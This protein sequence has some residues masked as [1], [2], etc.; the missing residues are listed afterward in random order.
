MEGTSYLV[1][2]VK[3]ALPP[4]VPEKGFQ[5]IGSAEYCVQKLRMLE[6]IG[7]KVFLGNEYDFPLR[8]VRNLQKP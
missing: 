5:I 3:E 2:A 7:K 8:G 1:Q 6:L 4:R